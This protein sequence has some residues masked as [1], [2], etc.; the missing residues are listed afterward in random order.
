MSAEAN[1]PRPQRLGDAVLAHEAQHRVIGC[2]KP[3]V[4]LD[5]EHHLPEAVGRQR[6]HH[7][8]QFGDGKIGAEADETGI[9]R[10]QF[11]LRPGRA[12][13]QDPGKP[14]Q[15]VDLRSELPET[16]RRRWLARAPGAPVRREDPLAPACG[17]AAAFIA[18]DRDCSRLSPRPCRR[19]REDWVPRL[20]GLIEGGEVSHLEWLGAVP[21]S[22]ATKGLE[23]QIEKVAFLK[24]LGAD[25]LILPD[26]PLVG[27]EHFSRR[28]TSRKPAALTRIKDPHRT[29]EVACFLRLTMLRVTDASLTLLDHRIAALWRAARERAEEA[30]ASRLRRFRELLGDLAGLAG[31]EALDAAELRS[32]LH[33]LIARFETERDTTQ[34]SAIR[35]E[36]GRKSQDLARL[37]KTAR[38]AALAVPADHQLT[39]AFATLD[40]VAASSAATL[41]NGDSQPF[42]LSWQGLIEQP[43]RAAALGCFRAATLIA[44]KRALRNRSISVAH[45]LSHRAPEDKLIP[46]KLWQRSHGRFIRDLNLPASPEK[47]LQRLEAG[48]TAGLAA[49]AEAVEAGTVAIKDFRRNALHSIKRVAGHFEKAD[50]ERERQPVQG[51]SAFSNPGKFLL[52][53]REEMFDLKC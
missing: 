10:H 49:M 43:D 6:R 19:E 17:G 36:L 8:H 15:A 13:Q 32:R 29:I 41:P 50:V 47:Y 4:R 27:L 7:A 48:L 26:L 21:S 31:D 28:M 5:L 37:L 33:G 11:L 35:Q 25:R 53:E 1:R 44:L 34:V 24:E 40:A 42:G 14:G 16:G 51:T 45:S 3:P 30:R 23:E 2:A 20:L 52:V 38:A 46:L 9:E 18:I 22:R 12:S 39:A